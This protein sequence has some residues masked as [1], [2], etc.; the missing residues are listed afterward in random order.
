MAT[1]PVEQ[2]AL[3]ALDLARNSLLVNLRFMGRGKK[4]V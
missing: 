2:L 4:I 1:E 3:Q